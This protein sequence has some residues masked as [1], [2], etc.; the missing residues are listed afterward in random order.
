[1]DLNGI[2]LVDKPSGISSARVVSII[3]KKFNIKK[4]GHAGTL[5]PMA[6]GLLVVLVGRSTRLARFAEGGPK[7]YSG[8]MR[9]GIRSDSDDITGKLSS[10]TE[11]IPDFDVIERAVQ[12][13]MGQISQR[14]PTV[15]A[16]K[17]AGKRAYK[18]ARA[19]I[20]TELKERQIE[21]FEYKIS[22]HSAGEIRFFIECSKGT[23]IR[24]LA[25]DL[26]ELLGCG[27]C[28]SSLRREAS[29]P[30][31]VTEAKAPDDLTLLDLKD[32]TTLCRDWSVVDLTGSDAERIRAG[33]LRPAQKILPE[34]LSKRVI[35]CNR[36]E[37]ESLGIL[38]YSPAGWK[39]LIN[40]Q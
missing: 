2:F 36:D 7:K 3:K 9:L 16:V 37:Q 4:V 15:S 26:G 31:S 17:V 19:G 11:P 6:T 33:D 5:D 30:F 18:L 22:Q 28:L 32:W 10:A 23:Y 34:N 40:M 39:I 1:M 38:E 8:R 35:Y 21:I 29:L 14:P 12:N 25:R 13:F 20:A 27:A 24:S